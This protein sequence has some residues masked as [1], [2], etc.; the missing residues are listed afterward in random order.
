MLSLMIA[1]AVTLKVSGW[2]ANWNP[3]SAKSFVAHADRIDEAMLC[4]MEVKADG[5]VVRRNFPAA[6]V[7]AIM[8]S[9]KLKK[10]KLFA[11]ASNATVDFDPERMTRVFASA[12]LQKKHI[13]QLVRIAVSDHFDGID[14]DYES[15]KAVDRDRFTA[16]VRQ[17]AAACHGAGLKLSIAVHP[18]TSEPG[19]WDGPQSQDWKAIGQAV[20]VFRIMCYDNHWSTGD[21]G[22][23]AP[24]TWV[25]Q[26]LEF[27]KTVVP[28]EKIETGI[29]G[30]G[31]DWAKKPADSLTFP[32]FKARFPKFATNDD[33]SGEIR[34]EKGWFGGADSA[35][36][37]LAI[38]K[39]LGLRGTALWYIGSEQ[40]EFWDLIKP[41]S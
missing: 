27:A 16:F 4:Y 21:P 28:K 34:A 5:T 19:N 3:D 37:K 35:A 30:Y 9:A 33:S 26:V 6:E 39:E 23:I 31:Y 2:L 36:R 41:R 38:T 20:D 17:C 22:P 15:M 13:A 12:E 11:M 29:A 7:A 10:V 1:S 18:K 32:D 24:D 25:K 8:R 40:P 14:L